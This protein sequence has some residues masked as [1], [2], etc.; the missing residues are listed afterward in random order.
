M[1]PDKDS[2][3]NLLVAIVLSVAVLL[4]WQMF[5]AGPKLK[6]EQER[7]QRIQQE[8][9]QP[10]AEPGVP[11]TGPAAVPGAAPQSQQGAAPTG[12]PVV[13]ETTRE[14]S[15]QGQRARPHRHA[16]PAGVD[17]P[18][19][20]PHRRPRAHQVSRDRRPQQS[21]CGA[22]LALGRAPSLLRRVRLGVGRRCQAAAAGRRDGVEARAG[23]RADAGFARDRSPGTTA[24]ASPSGA[25]SLSTT[26]TC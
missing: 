4:G 7:R 1:F 3:K 18:Q 25:R 2:Q 13:A 22:V 10:K 19:G 16:E 14:D 15:A 5:Y 17:R 9:A 20:R 26:T 11:K 6:E 24:R 8:Q 23:Q 21:Q 12:T